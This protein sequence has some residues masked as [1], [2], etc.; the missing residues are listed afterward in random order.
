MYKSTIAIIFATVCTAAPANWIKIKE[1]TGANQA[2]RPFTIGRFFAKGEIGAYPQP[3]V[4]GTPLT[5][6]QADV[7]TRWRDGVAGCAITGATN[8]AP[9]VITCSGAH[10]Y[11]EA[12]QVTITGVGGNTAANATWWITPLSPTTFSLHG[13]TGNAN[14][15]GGG[16]ATGPAEG[17]VQHAIVSFP[18]T[19]PANST[20][21]VDFVNSVNPSSAGNPAATLAAALSKAALLNWDIGG[22]PGNW[23]ATIDL[24][25]GTTKTVDAKAILSGCSSISPDATTLGCRYWLAGPVLTQVIVEDRSTNRSYDTGFATGNPIHPWFIASAYAGY[26]GLKVDYI[27]ENTWAGNTAPSGVQMVDDAYQVVMKKGSPLAAWYTYPS[28]GTFNHWA[29]TRYRETAWQGSNPGS[30]WI[31]YNMPYVTYSGLTYNYDTSF[32]LPSS[33]WNPTNSAQ[34]SQLG[35]FSEP[36]M[37]SQSDGGKDPN[38]MGSITYRSYGIGGAHSEYGLDDR[39]DVAWM[40]SWAAGLTD[41]NARLMENVM[42]GNSEVLGHVNIHFRENLTGRSFCNATKN[43][44]AAG[45]SSADAYGRPVSIDARPNMWYFAQNGSANS[46][47][48]ASDQLPIAGLQAFSGS[49]VDSL[50]GFAYELSHSW[51]I[52]YLRYALTGD[53][54]HLE[55]LWF[56]PSLGLAVRSPDAAQSSRNGT[57]GF[58][59]DENRGGAWMMKFLSR[60]A[61]M[62]PSGTPERAY[63]REKLANNL[64]VR[65]G[66]MGLTT[67]AFYEP[68]STSRWSWGRNTVAAGQPN[69]LAMQ[70]PPECYYNSYVQDPTKTYANLQTWTQNLNAAVWMQT[71]DMGFAEARPVATYL[72]SKHLL[73]QILDTNYNPY[74]IAVEEEPMLVGDSSTCSNG[75]PSAA[76]PFFTTW[77]SAKAS[78]LPVAQSLSAFNGSQGTLTSSQSAEWNYGLIGLAAS[79][80]LPGLTDAGLDGNAAYA[81]MVA[82]TPDQNLTHLVPRLAIV[83]R[84]TVASAPLSSNKCDVNGDGHVDV[85]DVQI[86]ISG[87]LAGS[88]S[89]LD[90]NGACK[91][92]DPTS[93]VNSALSGT[94]SAK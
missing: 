31:D 4:G 11:Q 37:F 24:I 51:D 77:A 48:P 49:N 87:I 50:K 66:W 21:Q 44:I 35:G 2:S 26:A 56:Q 18:L 65:E 69:P 55:E 8:S 27:V 46:T 16:T 80:F 19:L 9:I 83:P 88:C 75:W 84:Q 39:F 54:Y 64:A 20:T 34:F 72:L 62:S 30:V 40:Y 92:I 6:W 5:S 25:N 89:P 70:F 13:S 74:L 93:L 33:Y 59:Y 45:Q 29:R 78:F 85:L 17:S 60:A 63:F 28:S 52:N 71:A 79:S 90:L 10:G 91:T 76:H 67:G 32:S 57:V 42:A 81:F 12:D 68:Q 41:P 22:G 38:A 3:S 82:N 36:Y 58:A 61:L 94:C 14:Y 23:G 7:K 86:V 73:H 43:C 53:Y 15:G 1:T 47:A